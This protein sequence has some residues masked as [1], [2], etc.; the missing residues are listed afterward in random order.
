MSLDYGLQWRRMVRECWLGRELGSEGKRTWDSGIQQALSVVRRRNQHQWAFVAGSLAG[1]RLDPYSAKEVEIYEP[2]ALCNV[3]WNAA[4]ASQ[5]PSF[6]VL[7]EKELGRI[8]TGCRGNFVIC[9]QDSL[10]PGRREA[11]WRQ[12]GESSDGMRA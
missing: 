6:N 3:E 7:V 11:T 5:C 4:E 8:C 1:R 12:L 9:T 2:V 10:M